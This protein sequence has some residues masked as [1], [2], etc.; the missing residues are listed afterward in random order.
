MQKKNL[1][2]SMVFT[3]LPNQ[4]GGG[5]YPEP[6]SNLKKKIRDQIGHPKHVLYLVPNVIAKALNVMYS[7]IIRLTLKLVGFA[8]ATRDAILNL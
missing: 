1:V 5:S 4:R 6:N 7:P 2:K 8:K 3:L